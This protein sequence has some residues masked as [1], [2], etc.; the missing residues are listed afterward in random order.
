MEA[1][2]TLV[3]LGLLV[4]G[5]V[6]V[7]PAPGGVVQYADEHVSELFFLSLA[8]VSSQGLQDLGSLAHDQREL[9]GGQAGVQAAI[10]IG[11]EPLVVVEPLGATRLV[12]DRR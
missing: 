9:L 4:D 5:S 8:V 11:P 2:P 10:A 7:D 1:R 6:D 12:D 3:L